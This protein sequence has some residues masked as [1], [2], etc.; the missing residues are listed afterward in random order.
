MTGLPTCVA[1]LNPRLLAV[2]GHVGPPTVVALDEVLPPG[3]L[4][5]LAQVV[6]GATVVARLRKMVNDMITRW[7]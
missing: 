4:A 2:S 6:Q 1:L 5:V 7:S 3:V